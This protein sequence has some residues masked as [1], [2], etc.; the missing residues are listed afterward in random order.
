MSRFNLW[1]Q[2]KKIVCV[3]RSDKIGDKKKQAKL[4]T[5]EPIS[6]LELYFN[7]HHFFF[8]SK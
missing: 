5:E 8:R 4:V 1:I 2:I 7:E 6:F 3:K